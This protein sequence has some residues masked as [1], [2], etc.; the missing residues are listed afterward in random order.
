MLKLNSFCAIALV[1]A[2]WQGS[3]CGSSTNRNSTS[4][5]NATA[6]TS[7]PTANANMNLRS[8]TPPPSSQER[9]LATGVWG[10]VGVKM[11][12]T[13]DGATLE[14]DCAHGTIAGRLAVNEN[15]KV[16][17]K[18]HFVREHGGPI[19]QGEDRSGVPATYSGTTEGDTLTLTITLDDSKEEIGTYTLTRGKTGRIRKC[20]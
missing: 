1:I 17:L 8:P 5:N 13:E 20:L 18:G 9:T 3:S 14:F 7:A 19:R 16:L 12:A 10:G 15:G 11:E 6:N 2:L 4:N